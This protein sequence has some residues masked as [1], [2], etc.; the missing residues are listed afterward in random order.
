M[1]K[2]IASLIVVISLCSVFPT[3]ANA[4]VSPV[5]LGIVPPVQFPAED[6]TITGLRLSALYGEQRNMYGLDF[7][8][9]GNITLQDFTGLA[10]SG[11]FNSTIGSTNII[12]LQLAG[13]TNINKSRTRVYGIQAA[14]GMNS[15]EA[16]A[17]IVG[18]QLSLVNQGPHMVVYGAQFG[19]YNVAQDVYGFQFGL[20]N[21]ADSL[22][23]IQIGLLNFNA[24]GMFAVSPIIN[25]GF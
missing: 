12:G 9:L 16:D 21:R 5:S 19:V 18:L 13:L 17:Q 3:D 6:F 15:N 14:I 22:H 11:V 10:V 24:T 25:V 4:A 7:G 20:I 8:L 23:G 1:Q 2:I